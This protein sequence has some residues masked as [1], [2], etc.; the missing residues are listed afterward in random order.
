[1]KTLLFGSESEQQSDIVLAQL[2]QEMYNAG[3]IL[4][5][6]KNL[7]RFVAACRMKSNLSM[8]YLSRTGVHLFRPGVNGTFKCR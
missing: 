6:L 4:L 1:M 7:H 5:L 3:L 2:S 8:F